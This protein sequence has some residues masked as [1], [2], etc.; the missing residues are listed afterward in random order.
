MT[1]STSTSIW[2]NYQDGV[3][4]YC[5]HPLPD[6][7]KKNQKLAE[8]LLTPTTKEEDHDR[9]ISYEDI[10]KEKWMTKE[11]LEVCAT[12][13]LKVFALGQKIAAEHGLILVDTKYEFGRDL[14]TGE[15]LLIDEVH[16]PDSSRYWLASSYEERIASGIEPENI[17]KE[18]LRLWFR[19]QCDPYKDEVLPE[20]P[21]DLVIELSRRYIS[22]YE[23]ITWKQ[24]DLSMGQDEKLIA[25]SIEA[26][27]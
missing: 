14:E 5:G 20:A 8:N 24:F 4:N 17:D 11:D 13:A 18:F 23:M 16:T 1:G 3:R 21:R 7:M 6:G 25:K 22:L 10:I 12:A 27:K 26:Y 19:E 15:I 2:K 9:P